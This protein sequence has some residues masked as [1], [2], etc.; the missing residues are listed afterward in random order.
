[1]QITHEMTEKPKVLVVRVHARMVELGYAGPPPVFG[2]RWESLFVEPPGAV[3][4]SSIRRGKGEQRT[5]RG[6]DGRFPHRSTG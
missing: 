1:M 6:E 4:W 5:A 3:R 2:E